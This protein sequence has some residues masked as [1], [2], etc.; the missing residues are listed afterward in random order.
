V[1]VAPAQR[2]AAGGER[3]DGLLEELD[4]RLSDERR[5]RLRTSIHESCELF[6]ISSIFFS[7][8]MKSSFSSL[9]DCSWFA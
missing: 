4:L 9:A 2:R 8:L 7:I 5:G 1:R 6:C 3:L